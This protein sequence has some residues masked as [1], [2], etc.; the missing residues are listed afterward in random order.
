M[1]S[2]TIKIQPGWHITGVGSKGR[3]KE[4]AKILGN[5]KLTHKDIPGEV[6]FYMKGLKHIVGTHD[7]LEIEL[8]IRSPDIL[9]KVFSQGRCKEEPV[10]DDKPY[11]DRCWHVKRTCKINSRTCRFDFVVLHH[12]ELKRNVLYDIENSY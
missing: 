7:C 11:A 6:Y 4:I 3:A 8:L 1:P 2:Y 10:H 9:K 5:T 12:T